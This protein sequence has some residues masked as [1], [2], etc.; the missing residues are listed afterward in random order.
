M[1][2][3]IATGRSG[4]QYRYCEVLVNL[5]AFDFST[6]FIWFKIGMLWE[7]FYVKYMVATLGKFPLIQYFFYCGSYNRNVQYF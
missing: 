3:H 4:C 2:V 7:Y 5:D 1:Y 6:K